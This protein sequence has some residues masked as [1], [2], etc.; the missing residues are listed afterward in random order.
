MAIDIFQTSTSGEARSAR[1]VCMQAQ[2][3]VSAVEGEGT[4]QGQ[5][6]VSCFIYNEMEYTWETVATHLVSVYLT[7]LLRWGGAPQQHCQQEGGARL[8]AG[9]DPVGLTQQT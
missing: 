7:R 4:A 9:D 1:G 2:H 8:G 5:T 3:K 6:H